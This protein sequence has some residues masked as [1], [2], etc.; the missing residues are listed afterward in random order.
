MSEQQF[1]NQF[2][3]CLWLTYAEKCFYC[4]RPLL[5]SDM[6]VDH[7]IP[8]SMNSKPIE[9]VSLKQRAVI[10]DEF[11]I[12]GYENLAPSCYGCNRDKSDILLEDGALQINLGQI[13]KKVPILRKNIEQKRMERDLDTTL[14]FIAR[15]ISAEKFSYENL[16]KRLEIQKRFPNGIFGASPSA[17]PMSPETIA[18]GIRF[19][20]NEG[21]IWAGSALKDSLM[22]GLNAGAINDR[23]YEEVMRGK[24]YYSIKKIS[25][26]EF[27]LKLGSNIRMVFQEIEGRVTVLSVHRKK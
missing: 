14:R 13:A 9:L 17:P 23:I 25:P 15:S 10:L 12:L 22:L 3:E 24:S 16:V 7:V 2:R 5:F 19:Q 4:K 11:N 27:L 20:E 8:E 26:S 1:S 6:K 18:S 21:I